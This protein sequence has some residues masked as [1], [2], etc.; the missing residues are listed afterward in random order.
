[1]PKL[2]TENHVLT[3]KP[4]GYSNTF[5]VVGYPG[6]FYFLNT[7]IQQLPE[8]PM[9]G[10]NYEATYSLNGGKEDQKEFDKFFG[11]WCSNSAYLFRGLP[12]CH[13]CWPPLKKEGRL[14]S[15]GKA[16]LPIFTMGNQVKTRWLP[17]A[18]Q[19]NL[20]AGVALSCLDKY[21]KIDLK[22]EDVPVGVVIKI[23]VGS[24]MAVPLSWLNPGEIVVQGPLRHDQFSIC[25]S[26]WLL[27]G[28]YFYLQDEVS[29]NKLF[30]QRPYEPNSKQAI[31]DWFKT[32]KG[33]Q[34][35]MG[36]L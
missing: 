20:A 15:E 6:K 2:L 5:E 29:Y 24:N 18:A 3:I 31:L 8:P 12:G 34:W 11:A 28:D 27:E 17:A 9:P 35:E 36:R 13:F 19:E 21:T 30:A 4:A 16:D 7:A 33:T 23:P 32:L 10:P 26:V 25:A 14:K 1:M 22:T